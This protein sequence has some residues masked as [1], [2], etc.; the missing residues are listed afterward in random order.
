VTFWSKHLIRLPRGHQQI[1]VVESAGGESLFEDT[2]SA[3]HDLA[4]IDLPRASLASAT[5][6]PTT[7]PATA[8]PQLVPRRI[9]VSLSSPSAS[10][11]SSP[12]TTTCFSS[13]PS[14][15]CARISAR[16]RA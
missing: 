5:T 7:R 10:S 15:W 8:R 12:D 1:V 11:T 3:D 14:C 6:S 2:F 13:P 16:R 9:R 4:E